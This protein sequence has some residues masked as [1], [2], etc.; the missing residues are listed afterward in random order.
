M[1]SVA[2]LSPFVFLL[3]AACSNREATQQ[4]EQQ[5]LEAA[6][7]GDQ[8]QVGAVLQQGIDVNSQDI[9][10]FTPLIKSAQ[11]GNRAVV[12]QLLKAGAM[13]NLSDKGGY[14]ALMQAAGNNHPDIHFEGSR[15]AG[16]LKLLLLQNPQDFGLCFETHIAN[17]IEHGI[18]RFPIMGETGFKHVT[19]GPIT[20]TPNGDYNGPDTITYQICD[21]TAPTPASRSI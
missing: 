3:L 5:L 20:Y 6:E 9:C 1:R 21:T 10:F 14:T 16:P 11:H 19:D 12:R 17:F 18:Y 2:S 15:S 7:R 13:V 4:L 8:R